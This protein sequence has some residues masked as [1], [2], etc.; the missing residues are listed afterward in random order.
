MDERDLAGVKTD[1]AVG[2]AAGSSVFEVAFD[3][4]AYGCQLT[5][6]L[7][8]ATCFQ[9]YFN[10]VVPLAMGEGLVS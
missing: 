7:V 4:T 1:S 6:N 9:L 3:G 10:Q 2:I 8:M 5:T